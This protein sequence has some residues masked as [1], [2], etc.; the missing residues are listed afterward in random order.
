LYHFFGFSHVTTE[1]QRKN[2]W[3][4]LRQKNFQRDGAQQKSI[5]TRR[6]AYGGGVLQGEEFSAA[7]GKK[8]CPAGCAYGMNGLL[9]CVASMERIV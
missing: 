1:K 2:E 5:V 8:F 6:H 3:Q 9:K 4:G 7:G